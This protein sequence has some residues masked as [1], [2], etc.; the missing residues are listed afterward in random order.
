MI[1]VDADT[2]AETRPNE[3]PAPM[4]DLPAYVWPGEKR[5]P[6]KIVYHAAAGYSHFCVSPKTEEKRRIFGNLQSNK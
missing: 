1:G 4:L 2:L 6:I 5:Y 3:T